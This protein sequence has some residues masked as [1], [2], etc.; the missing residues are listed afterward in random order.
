MKSILRRGIV[1]FVLNVGELEC[2]SRLSILGH[3]IEKVSPVGDTR[4]R[5]RKEREKEKKT[6]DV[7]ME[8][9]E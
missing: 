4:L 6:R 3:S 2:S 8:E 5:R 9:T 7:S 1:G